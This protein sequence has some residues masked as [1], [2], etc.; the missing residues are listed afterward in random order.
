MSIKNKLLF[1]SFM[2]KAKQKKCKDCK[3]AYIKGNIF[4]C[5]KTGYYIEPLHLICF[6]KRSKI[7]KK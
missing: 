5:Y 4:A 7:C 2:K 6:S 3:Y 1:N